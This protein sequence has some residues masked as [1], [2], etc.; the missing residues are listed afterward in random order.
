MSAAAP[1]RA[2]RRAGHVLAVLGWVWLGGVAATLAVDVA[3]LGSPWPPIV[4]TVGLVAGAIVGYRDTAAR[5]R[6]ARAIGD[7]DQIMGW[8]LVVGIV[9][10]LVAFAADWP[11]RAL[12]IVLVL[13]CAWGFGAG[14]LLPRAQGEADGADAER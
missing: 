4:N 9:A 12:A 1:S 11:W 8:S 14:L 7:R 5:D 3:G 10:V 2:R 6:V 13:A